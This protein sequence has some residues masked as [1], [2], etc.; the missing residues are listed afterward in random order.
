VQNLIKVVINL[1]DI[2]TIFIFTRK[3][4]IKTIFFAVNMI[5][6]H[7]VRHSTIPCSAET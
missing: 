7:D 3:K 2:K 6:F 1:F 4:E 5:K